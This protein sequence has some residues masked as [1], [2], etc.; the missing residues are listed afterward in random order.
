MAAKKPVAKSSKS[1]A[2]RS[3]SRSPRGQRSSRAGDKA[4]TIDR[5]R[6]DR[7]GV[8]AAAEPA[9]D[10]AAASEPL[11][12]RKKVQR[13]R[14]IDPTTCERDYSIEEVAFMNAMD[15]YK[16]TSGRMFPTC[17]EVLEVIRDLGYVKLSPSERSLL[18]LDEQ[19][20]VEQKL[21]AV[22]SAVD[23]LVDESA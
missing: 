10:A 20:P 9:S 23:S 14:Q 5:R 1:S 13:R 17:S 7:R 3:S 4:V 2:T 18:G 12:R 19:M 11:E 21:D 6:S 15:D 22:S 8:E 16:R